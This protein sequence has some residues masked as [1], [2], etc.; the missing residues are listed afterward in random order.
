VDSWIFGDLNEKLGPL[1]MYKG[2]Y[3]IDEHVR[4]YNDPFRVDN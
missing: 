1:N 2:Y 3:C 4:Y